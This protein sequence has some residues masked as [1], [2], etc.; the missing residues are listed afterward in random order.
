MAVN[1]NSQSYH[2][3]IQQDKYW[4]IYCDNG[5]FYEYIYKI[6]FTGNDTL[7]DGKQYSLSKQYAYLQLNPGPL[8]PPFV[9][10]T[11]AYQTSL[12]LREDTIERKVY[13]YNTS[14]PIGDQLMY[15]FSLNVGD[16]LMSDFCT[17]MEG[18]HLV[19]LSV[20]SVLLQNGEVRRKFNFQDP[21]SLTEGNY[22]EGIGGSQGI[23]LPII[24]A[25]E[26]TY[27]YGYFCVSQGDF[28]LWGDQCNWYFVG[29]EKLTDNSKIKIYPNPASETIAIEVQLEYLNQDFNLYTMKTVLVRTIR[30]YSQNTRVDI[31]GLNPGSYF[32]KIGCDSNICTGKLIIY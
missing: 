21:I 27:S 10:D 26:Q 17:D 8:I 24:P 12:F 4:D 11:I 29:T 3:L 23:F 16:T 32:Y 18:N 20:D 28:D 14:Y 31:K 13:I 9:I 5:F 15:D 2:K 25:F 22:I 30:L 19:L 6:Y 7:I 1:A